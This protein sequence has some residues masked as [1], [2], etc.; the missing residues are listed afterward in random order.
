MKIRILGLAIALVTLL[1]SCA[2][3]PETN[4]QISVDKTEV[5]PGDEFTVT[6]NLEHDNYDCAEFNVS[7]PIDENSTV[8]FTDRE[9]TWKYANT[10]TTITQTY[11]VKSD[12]TDFGTATIKVGICSK[13]KDLLPDAATKGCEFKEVSINVTP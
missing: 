2:K 6:V 7:L 12:L 13:C 11:T 8:S 9:E 3:L 1:G 5:S 10:G 4:M